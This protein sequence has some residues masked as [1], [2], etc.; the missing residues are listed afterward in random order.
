MSVEFL[1]SEFLLPRYPLLGWQCVR[2]YGVMHPTNKRVGGVLVKND[3]GIYSIFGLNAFH[4]V[5]QDWAK[6]M[7]ETINKN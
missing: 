7:D 4:S 1:K 2:K 3:K 6:K 5:P